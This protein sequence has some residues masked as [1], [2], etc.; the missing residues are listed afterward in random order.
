MLTFPT[1]IY[2]IITI[3][4]TKHA[5]NSRFTENLY[6][7]QYKDLF[8]AAYGFYVKNFYELIGTN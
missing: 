2:F 5:V 4:Q 6:W 3:I 1:E 7:K 8:G